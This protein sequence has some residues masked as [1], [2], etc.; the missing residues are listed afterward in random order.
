[1]PYMYALCVTPSLQQWEEPYMCA[2]YVC[3][4]CNIFSAAMGPH[5]TKAYIEGIHIRHTYKAYI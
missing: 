4:I 2:L 1:M 3:L 5:S